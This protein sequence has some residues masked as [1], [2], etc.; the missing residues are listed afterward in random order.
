M[1]SYHN[2]MKL[3]INNRKKFGKHTNT[4]ILN[5]TLLINQLIKEEIT[6]G[7]RK[8]NEM[9]KNEDSAHQGVWDSPKAM[10]REKFRCVNTYIKRGKI[11]NQ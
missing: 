9:D 11:S 6:R 4:L 3:E 1:C 5:N 7:N 8:H 2:K 10:L